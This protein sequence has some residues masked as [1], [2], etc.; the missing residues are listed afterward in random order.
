MLQPRACRKGAPIR[1]FREGTVHLHRGALDLDLADRLPEFRRQSIGLHHPEERPLWVRG[2]HDRLRL[3]VSA[4]LQAHATDV[5]VL[6]EDP[7]HGG[8]QEDL[9][10]LSARGLREGL[11]ERAHPADRESPRPLDAVHVAEEVVTQRE[12]GARRGGGGEMSDHAL[13]RES[14]LHL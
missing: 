13:V 2:G 6:H 4:V 14:R 10:T 7:I 5:A 1:E 8:V 11:R 9:H 12:R 3:E